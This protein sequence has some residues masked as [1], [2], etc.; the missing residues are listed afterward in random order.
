MAKAK[1]D[2]MM[3]TVFLRSAF[4]LALFAPIAAEAGE[5]NVLY[6]PQAVKAALGQG[7]SVLLHFTAKW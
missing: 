6:S 4:F 2:L 5:G 3:R 1:G 7:C